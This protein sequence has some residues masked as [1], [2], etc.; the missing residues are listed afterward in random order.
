LVVSFSSRW[1]LILRGQGHRR[2]YR[3]LVGYRLAGF[4][5]TYF[6]PGPQLGGEPLQVYLL[7]H[8]ENVPITSAVA[9][10]TLDKLLELLSSF[11][12]LIIGVATILASGILGKE[13][14]YLLL[15]LPIGL[16]FLPAGY[17]LSLWKGRQPATKLIRWLADRFPGS[18]RLARLPASMQAAEKEAGRFFQDHPG[19]ILAAL[20][21]SLLI[22]VLVVLEFGLALRFL[23]LHLTLPEV[24]ILLTA[25]RLAF[26]LPIPAGIGTLET[27]Q[28][29]A[30]GL[31]GA[32]PAI[33]LSLS[34]LIRVRDTALGSLGLW[35]GGLLTRS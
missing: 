16:L 30:M 21:I 32:S 8:R 10:V 14:N 4:G 29:L 26:L 20:F 9:S 33:G 2:S 24:I 3:S 6:T 34:L 28:M 31:I 13:S 5:I 15:L 11:T 25:A 27:G 23:G 18:Q 17:L 35:L 19:T 12:F 1:W 7:T 22:W